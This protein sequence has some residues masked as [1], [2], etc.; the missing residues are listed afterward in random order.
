MVVLTNDH[1]DHWPTS[2]F[3]KFSLFVTDQSKS[4]QFVIWF[5][6]RF[7]LQSTMLGKKK[8]RNSS[9]DTVARQY[10]LCSPTRTRQFYPGS[11]EELT[12]KGKHVFEP[13]LQWSV[14]LLNRTKARQNV[15]LTHV[16]NQIPTGL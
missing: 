2:R 15:P 10:K 13:T 3:A 7:N 12:I 8:P 9:S 11:I 16:E 14:V 6:G 5:V 1:R 4:A